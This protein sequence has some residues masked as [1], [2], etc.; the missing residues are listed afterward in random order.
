MSTLDRVNTELNVCF[1]PGCV[2]Y[3]SFSYVRLD[4][5]HSSWNFSQLSKKSFFS[6]LFC[7]LWGKKPNKKCYFAWSYRSSFFSHLNW[8]WV[9]VCVIKRKTVS[10]THFTKRVFNN[11]NVTHTFFFSPPHGKSNSAFILYSPWVGFELLLIDT[12][13]LSHLSFRKM[14]VE[15]FSFLHKPV[16]IQERGN[17][18]QN[19]INK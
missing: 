14:G 18:L 4:R 15:H 8:F 10:M 16:S 12:N 13:P 9:G 1:H 6:L 11:R 5:L 7:S 17:F 19:K 3:F 2:V